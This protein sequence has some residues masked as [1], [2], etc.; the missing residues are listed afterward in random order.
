[1]WH[2]WG[3]VVV[4]TEFWWGNVRER[5]YLEDLDIDGIIM[6]KWILMRIGVWTGLTR[7]V[8]GAVGGVL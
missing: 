7:P 2:A 6:L 3:R 1:M 4:H 8:T 5:E